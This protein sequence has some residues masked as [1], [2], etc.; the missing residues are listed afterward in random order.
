MRGGRTDWIP[1]HLGNGDWEK[2]GNEVA[3]IATA[4]TSPRN[5]KRGM[6]PE[7]CGVK[8]QHST[9]AFEKER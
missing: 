3:E 6:A 1:W 2:R 9:L 4:T 7:G 8:S 5:D